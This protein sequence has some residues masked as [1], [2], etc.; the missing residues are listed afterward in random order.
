MWSKYTH[1]P[2]STYD[3]DAARELQ[4]YIM[5]DSR[6][7]PYGQGMGRNVA[8]NL[9]KKMQ[10]GTY[11]SGQVPKAWEYVVAAAAKAY[12]KEHGSGAWYDTFSATTRRAVAETM[13]HEF[14]V[15]EKIRGNLR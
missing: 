11:R 12:V 5:S 8:A 3:S 2:S 10:K 7:N 15:E 14:E 1:N 4:L 6:F 13:A 9:R